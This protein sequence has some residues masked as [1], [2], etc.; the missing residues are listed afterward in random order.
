MKKIMILVIL[1]ILF[2]F[3]IKIPAYHELNDLAIINGIGV[4]YK[5][6]SY[7]IYMKEMIPT[8]SDDG[9]E[10]KYKIYTGSGDDLESALSEITDGTK[11]KLYYKKCKFLVTDINY[12]DFINE[13]L[14]IKPKNIYHP[15]TNDV[16][17]ILE[18][19]NS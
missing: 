16:E 15:P 3:I 5:N 4:S 2:G 19:T 10:Y 12:S 6:G 11:K 1:V 14:N 18:K 17:S 7:T 13:V 8:R 9:I